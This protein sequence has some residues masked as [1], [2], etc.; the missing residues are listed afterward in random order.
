MSNCIDAGDI[1]STVVYA[2]VLFMF[3]RQDTPLFLWPHIMAGQQPAD[4]PS[5]GIERW[6]F[7]GRTD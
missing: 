2:A 6:D 4:W 1:E 3:V 5:A 7:F